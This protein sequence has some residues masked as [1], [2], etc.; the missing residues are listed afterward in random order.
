MDKAEASRLE[1]G[2]TG[3]VVKLLGAT[4]ELAARG[5]PSPPDMF[6][7]PSLSVAKLDVSIPSVAG[8]RLISSPGP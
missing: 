6:A 7:C 4:P 2:R 8:I 1:T 3:V 5:N